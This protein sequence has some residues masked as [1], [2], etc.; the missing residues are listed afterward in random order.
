MNQQL[1]VAA[2]STI[3]QRLLQTAGGEQKLV[4]FC[5]AK[6]S[7]RLRACGV[8]ANKV[9]TIVNLNTALRAEPI[10]DNELAKW[11]YMQLHAWLTQFYGIGTWT[12][13]MAAIFYLGMP[14][15][16]PWQDVALMRGGRKLIH[17]RFGEKSL[18][19]YQPYRSYLACYIWQFI[20]S[21]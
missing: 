7:D 5:H 6:N 15:I 10:S 14:D 4:E 21:N 8:S 16:W 9:K 18:Q 12:T 3:W 2:G 11:D 1:S 17:P 20:D 19:Q 13:D